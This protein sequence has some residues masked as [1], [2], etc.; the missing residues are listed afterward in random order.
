MLNLVYKACLA[1]GF[2]DLLCHPFGLL[3]GISGSP[4]GNHFSTS[5][6]PHYYQRVLLVLLS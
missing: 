5:I 2:A 4:I 6:F 1:Y 3:L